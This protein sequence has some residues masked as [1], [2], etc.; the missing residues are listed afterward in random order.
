MEEAVRNVQ[1]VSSREEVISEAFA[2]EEKPPAEFILL[3]NAK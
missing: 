2:N 3:I 1:T